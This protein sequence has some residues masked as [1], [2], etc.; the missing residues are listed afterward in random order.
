MAIN[1]ILFD[2]DNTLYDY[3]KAHKKALLRTYDVF[4]RCRSISL[5]RFMDLFKMSR[6]EIHRE[7]AGTAA[8]HNRILY[9]QRLVEKTHGNVEPRLILQLHDVYWDTL[10]KNMKLRRGVLATLRQLSK[11]GVR[12]AVVSNL[13]TRIQLR[14]LENLGLTQYVDVLITSEEAGVEKPH[15]LM[16]LLALNKLGLRPSEAM[17]V[18]DN[19]VADIEGAK[20]LGIKTVL[21]TKDANLLK[22]LCDYRTPDFSIRRLPQILEILVADRQEQR[23]AA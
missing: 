21:L 22:T 10:L 9:F 13:T 12:I 18:G 2:L 1:A 23:R 15:P 11:Q 4:R 8:S 20:A 3:E 6:A 14:K 16:F 19:P 7:L 17:M 5:H